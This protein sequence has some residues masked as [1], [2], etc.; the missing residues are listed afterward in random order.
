[1]PTVL[2]SRGEIAYNMAP[3]VEDVAVDSALGAIGFV[4]NAQYTAGP[5]KNV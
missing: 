3:T 4:T 5:V 2:A 1:L